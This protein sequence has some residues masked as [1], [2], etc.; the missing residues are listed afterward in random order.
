[1]HLVEGVG[2]S[3]FVKVSPFGDRVL[4]SSNVFR[5]GVDLVM[6]MAID[7]IEADTPQ[8]PSRDPMSS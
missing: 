2:N 5:D 1:M 7:T 4:I 8:C 3:S 6:K